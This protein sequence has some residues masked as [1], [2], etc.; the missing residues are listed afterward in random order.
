MT[1]QV[2]LHDVRHALEDLGRLRFGE[3]NVE[4][5]IREIVHTTHSIFSV[6]GAGLMWCD[7]EPRPSGSRHR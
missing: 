3:M 6:D 7:A 1:M 2:S 5:A 4:D